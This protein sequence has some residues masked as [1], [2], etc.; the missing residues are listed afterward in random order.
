M[1]RIKRRTRVLGARIKRKFENSALRTDQ[2]PGRSSRS[3]ENQHTIKEM[4]ENYLSFAAMD[5]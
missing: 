3:R 5:F 4:W 1:N 2:L